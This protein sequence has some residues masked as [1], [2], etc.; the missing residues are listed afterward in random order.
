VCRRVGAGGP[1]GTALRIQPLTVGC[2]PVRAEGQTATA[3]PNPW[4]KEKGP[5]DGS[6]FI[7]SYEPC[8]YASARL[9]IMPKPKSDSIAIA[10]RAMVEGSGTRDT[11]EMSSNAMIVFPLPDELMKSTLS[12]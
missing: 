9:R 6:P 12:I 10:M 11:C 8:A 7:Q 4:R 3:A 5:P 2:P 1:G